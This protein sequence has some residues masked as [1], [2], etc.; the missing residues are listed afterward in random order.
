MLKDGDNLNASSSSAIGS[1]GQEAET[2]AGDS[3]AGGER[4]PSISLPKSG[5]AIKGIGEKFA[6]NLITGTGSMTLPVATSPG[7][8]GLSLQLNLS[9]DSGAGNGPFGFGW[10]LLL[11]NITRKTDKGL[12]QYRDAEES[13]V[14]IISG[15]EDLVPV[16]VEVDGRWER[17]VLPPRTLNGEDYRVQRYRP[18]AEGLFVRLER[19]TNLQTGEAHWRS[20]TRDNIT[21][22]YGKDDNS[23]VF[24]A[25]GSDSGRVFSWLI[26]QRYD[27]KG[28]AIVYEYAAENDEK[29]DRREV[30]ERNRT[31]TA[32]RYLKSVK[33]GNRTPNRDADWNPTDAA[34]LPDEDWMFEVVFDYD[35]GHYE[36]L[37]PEPNLSEAEQH[38]FV[39]AS[40]AAGDTWS[41]RPDPFSTYRA[42]FEI[43][44]YRRCRR[45]L[46]FHRFDELGAEPCLVRSTE[47]EY[48]DLDYTQPTTIEVELAHRGSTRFASFILDVTQSGYVRDETRPVVEL[49]GVRSVTYLKK[50]LPPL[51]FEYSKAEIHDDIRELD[52]ESLENLPMGLDGISYQWLDL[53][54][55]GISGILTEQAGAW[56]YKPNL[57]DGKFGPLEVVAAKPSLAA[58][59][60][61]LQQLIDLAA[62]GQQDLVS[63]AGPTPGFYERVNNEG[64][65]PFRAFTRLPNIRWDEPNL[66]FVDLNGD[67]HADILITEDEVLTWYP[68]LAEEG[69]D[70]ARHVHKPVDE[71]QGPRLV[72]ADGTQSIYLADMCGDGLSALVRIRNG[73]VCYWPNLGYGLFG[74]KVT[75]DNAPRF[76]NPDQ[77]NH[78]RVRLAD[79]DGSGVT[80]IIYLGRDGVRLYFNQSGN[81]W[82]EARRLSQFPRVDSLSS[83]MA[84]DL[85][86]NGTACLVWASPVPDDSRRPMRYIDLMGGQKP[87]LLTAFVNNLGAETRIQYAPSTKFYLADKLAGKP[88]I[89]KIPFPVQVLERIE[90][91][92]RIS[93][94]RFVKRYAY[95]HGY[96]DGFER[97]F[98]GFGMVEQ[99]ETEEFAA[100]NASQQIP[101]GTNPEQAAHTPPV[102]TRTW[103]HTG[104]YLGREHVSDFFAGLLNEQDTG[105]YYREPGLTDAQARELLLEKSVLPAGLTGEEE[106]ESCRALKG[107]MLRQ[108]IYALDGTQRESQPY[109]VT[110]QNFAIRRS[111]PKAG[112][113]H[114]VFFAHAHEVI[115][116]HYERHPAD[117][118]ITHKLA[119]EVDEFGNVLKEAAI[120]YGRRAN[121][122][123]VN[124][125]GDIENIP[126]PLLTLLSPPDRA[127]QTTAL[128]TYTENE[129]TNQV[130]ED[131]A[132]RT[133]MACET[134]AYELT[135]LMLPAGRSRFTLDEMLSAAASAALIAYEQTPLPGVLQKRLIEHSR[136]LYRR[137]DLT[138]PL[139]LGQLQSMALP[140]ESY[141]LAFTPELLSE[142]YDGRVTSAMLE[143]DGRYVHS[144]G[145]DN[146][147]VPSRRLF[148]SPDA[149]DTPLQELTYARAHFFLPH[150]YRDPFHTVAVSTETF[151]TYDAHNLLMLETLDAL[152]NRVTAGE[153]DVVGTLTTQ[154]NDYRVLQPRLV[155]CPNRNRTAV[156]FDALGTVVGTAVMGKPE[157]IPARGDR[158]DAT[159]RADL[160]DAVIEQFFADP[161]ASLAASLLDNATTRVVNNP[162]AYW[163]EPVSQQKPPAS[164]ATI[165]RETHASDPVPAGGL[166]IQVSFSY[167]DGF[168]REVQKKT[169]AEAGPVP[170]RDPATGLIITA[171]GQPVMTPGNV[172]PR[173]V[174]TGWTV[175]NNKGKPIRQY[176]PFFTDLHRFEFDV[177]IGVSPVLFYDPAGR[178]TATLHPDHTWEKVVFG[179]WQQATWDVSDTVLAVD[180]RTDP[181]VGDLFQ[182]LPDTDYLP[183]WHARRIGGALGT[184]EQ[185]AAQKA[186]IHADSPT[187]AHFDVLGRTFLTVTHNKF[188]L[189]NS[190]PAGPPTEEFYST[191]VL[192]DIEGNQREVHDAHDR[193]VMR[194]QYNMLGRRV[195]QASMEAGARWTFDDVVDKNLYV[196]DSRAQQLRTVYDALR[197]AVETYLREGAGAELMIGRSV[198]GET[199]PDPE[200]TN[201]RKQVAQ[202]FDQAGVVSSEYDFKG[203]LLNSRRQLARN[204]KTTLNWSGAVPLEPQTYTS[205][206]VYD[207]L[208]RPT[209]LTTPDSSVIHLAYNEASLL[210]GIGAHLRG[211][212]AATPFVTRLDYDAKGQCTLIDYGNNTRTTYVYDRLT[213]RLAQMLT[214]RNASDFPDD[215]PQPAPVGWPGCQVQNLHYTYDPT[216]NVTHIRDD[217]QQTIY[218][219]NRRVEPSAVYT[220]DALSRLIEATGREHLGLAG[221]QPNPPTA[222]DAFNGFHTGMDHPG[223]GNAVGTYVEQYVYDAVGNILSMQH[224]GSDPAH[225]GWTRAYAYN[226]TSQLEAGK[227]NNRLSQVV[228]GATTETYL[229]DAPAG[230]HGNI[231]S[232]PHL[233]SMKWDYR[234][235]LQATSRQIVNDG[236]PETTWY[237][238][239]AGGQ[240]VRKVT[241]AEAAAGQTPTRTK[242]RIYLGGFEL[243]R[244]YSGD[245]STV[246]LERETLHIMN[247]RQRIALVET[248]AP[249]NPPALERLIR[250]QLSNHLGSASLE[251]DGQSRII[252][253]E[254]YTPYGSTSYQATDKSILAAAKRYRHTGKERDEET[255]LSYHERRYYAPW[256]GRWTSCDPAGLEDGVNLFA[257]AHDN[258]IRFTD[259]QGTSAWDVVRTVANFTMNWIIAPLVRMASNAVVGAVIGGLIGFASAGIGGILAGAVIGAIVGGIAGGIHGWSMAAAGTYNWGSGWSWLMFLADNTWSVLN[260]FI[261]S[262]WSSMNIWNPIDRNLSRGTGQLV[263]QRSWAGNYATTFGNVTAGQQVPRHERTHALQARIFG[264]LFYPLML[265]HYAVNIFLPYWLIYHNRRYPRAPITS[266]GQYFS[267]GVYPHTFA[268]EWAYA[269]QGS[270]P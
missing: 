13:D 189:S 232:A 71:E 96:F 133:P 4:S 157:D 33:Y 115:N 80:D 249:D 20:I 193:I 216:G 183:T 124:E 270:P 117:P 105:E 244:E 29:V 146:W 156:A 54:G 90:T 161:G 110:E 35:E 248:R 219:R 158:L 147:W 7:R 121:L 187:L 223:N 38:R 140:F 252:S 57:G 261:G 169:Q 99:T 198:Y 260:T 78:Q 47:F 50:S 218:F 230:L 179:A 107:S 108:E 227:S 19:W 79:I 257:Y 264:S 242:E 231:T 235:Q 139:A 59:S 111:Q 109:T 98:R 251:L 132:H 180:P 51:E 205:R 88:W 241:D 131:D 128:I 229:Y 3:S 224:R 8:S 44:T 153:R 178:T 97:E 103:F 40:L 172:S 255:G 185:A 82:S 208:N 73:E 56:F 237:V 192:F 72:L 174:G 27:D 145:D 181:D 203:N 253:Y 15:A 112:N 188:K 206:T 36:E 197:R 92:D 134:R 123:V 149:A 16:L 215:C 245:G 66:R 17:E 199:L 259:P 243:Y 207:A 45:V 64:W 6:A 214:E 46:M 186:S 236:T 32:N 83:V 61:G 93:G 10:N 130:A 122:L 267:R 62:D 28:N 31:R 222:P 86:G 176:E 194:Y 21:T 217:A 118:R 246:T 30:N 258:P 211:A 220:Y 101:T 53:N 2:G 168:G 126:N 137:N 167:S 89:T 144:E 100:L 22:L 228:V 67:G 91:H 69:F 136:T 262:I 170:L 85:L 263:Y 49:N 152:N 171:G 143:T 14:F 247:G 160:T 164:T 213:F 34:Q 1:K 163:R 138:G 221:V 65:K 76:D 43:R 68:S 225:A 11:P 256:L 81:R 254:E 265:A 26:C 210:E 268:E 209:D 125:Q 37:A 196:W 120:G 166:K 84:V 74:A 195:Q 239:D 39:R 63:F 175:F 70:S 106:R 135:G 190:P 95:H 238:Y 212:A 142:I 25:D 18:R 52:A 24:T 162:N 226:E 148:Y 23:K 5:G 155:M 12:P 154:G 200:A 42:G 250:Y 102:L 41:V 240:R 60:G 182:R 116:Y 204:Y 77:F 184:E 114:A 177:R 141:K 75:M 104:V 58:L 165:A 55:E 48:A 173:W 94:N 129:V 150:R 127:K 113:R 234:D 9:Y 119:L 159:F 191:R 201:L 266:F 269:V 87:H 233:P 202:I 151:V